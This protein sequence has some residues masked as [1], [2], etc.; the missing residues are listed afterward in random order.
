MACHNVPERLAGEGEESDLVLVPT[1]IKSRDDAAAHFSTD[2][3]GNSCITGGFKEYMRFETGRFK[4]VVG[5]VAKRGLFVCEDK[6]FLAKRVK[7]QFGN[8]TLANRDSICPSFRWWSSNRMTDR[9][10]SKNILGS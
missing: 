2:H 9:N 10:C 7:V 4:D 5:Q 1:G 6:R 3:R 8:L